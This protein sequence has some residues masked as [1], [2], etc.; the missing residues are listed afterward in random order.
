MADNG[1]RE[2]S[3]VHGRGVKGGVMMRSKTP[4][5]MYGILVADLYSLA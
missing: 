2:D 5:L 4:A 1:S 3:A